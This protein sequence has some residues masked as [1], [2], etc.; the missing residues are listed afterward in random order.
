MGRAESGRKQV[1]N[2]EEDA[3]SK[4]PGATT[5]VTREAEGRAL[6]LLPYKTAGTAASCDRTERERQLKWHESC[7]QIVP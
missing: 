1:K 2:H 7:S 3:S 6:A 4:P 5:S